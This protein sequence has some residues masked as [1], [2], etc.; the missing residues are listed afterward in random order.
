MHPDQLRV[1]PCWQLY[2][3][4]FTCST[5]LGSTVIH[6]YMQLSAAYATPHGVEVCKHETKLLQQHLTQGTEQPT[7][8]EQSNTGSPTS[9]YALIPHS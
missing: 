9:R 8:Q 6:A 7:Y 4:I 1:C 2:N 3:W 5:V